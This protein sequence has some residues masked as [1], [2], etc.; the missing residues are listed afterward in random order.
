[1]SNTNT[2]FGFQWLGSAPGGAPVTGGIVERKIAS[3]YTT[4]IC[5]GD[6]VQSLSTGY[7]SLAANGLAGSAIAGVFMG[8][9]Y[10][11]TSQGKWI[12]SSYWPTGDHAVDGYAEI[13]PIAGV[14]PQLFKVQSDVNGP[15]TLA[16]VGNNVDINVGTQTIA[17]GFG[18]SGMTLA[19]SGINTTNTL[20]FTIVKLWSDVAPAGANGTDN[21]SAYNIVLVASNPFT[22][23]GV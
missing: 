11:S 17:G 12:Y 14:P 6:L 7:V 5:H 13:V 21:T 23:T 20:P 3:G 9:R 8:C 15:I 19:T 10:L 2:P 16:N 22:A 1:M 18:I 4:A